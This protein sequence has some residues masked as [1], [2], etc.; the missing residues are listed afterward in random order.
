MKY[1]GKLLLIAIFSLF[2]S[3]WAVPSVA[4]SDYYR[5]GHGRQI[6]RA[7]R[8]HILHKRH[9]SPAGHLFAI[10]VP[11]LKF[12][13]R[14]PVPELKFN[15]RFPAPHLKFDRKYGDQS[16]RPVRSRH[17]R[18]HHLKSRH[19]RKRHR[20]YLGSS[21]VYLGSAE[22]EVI[23]VEA[24]PQPEPQVV[25]VKPPPEPEPESRWEVIS[26]WV[27]PVMERVQV[28]GYWA[29]GIKKT[30]TGD[31]WKF[32]TDPDNKVWVAETYEWQ[33]KQPGYYK[34]SRVL[35]D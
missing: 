8:S 18:R 1:V 13:Y 11:E 12:N 16:F 5:S 32:E 34:E 31:G 3:A 20:S 2:A 30:W 22:P 27:P 26:E 23:V 25:I 6:S 10:P 14:F 4:G 33:E 17:H 19:F 35:V 29:Y 7:H 21:Y 28:P 24:P 15:Y 9:R